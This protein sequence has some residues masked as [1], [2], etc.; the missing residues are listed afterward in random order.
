[1]LQAAPEVDIRVLG[2]A[3]PPNEVPVF[4]HQYFKAMQA[5]AEEEGRMRGTMRH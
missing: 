2:N 1:M 5:R 4:R 3:M